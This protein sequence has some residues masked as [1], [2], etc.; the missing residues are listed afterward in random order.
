MSYSPGPSYNSWYFITERHANLSIN[1]LAPLATKL[2]VHHCIPETS[3]KTITTLG[4][5]EFKVQKSLEELYASYPIYQWIPAI[6]ALSFGSSLGVDFHKWEQDD[7]DAR[8]FLKTTYP[9][10]KI[11]VFLDDYH[12]QIQNTNSDLFN[13]DNIPSDDDN[14]DDL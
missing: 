9:W 3:P 8:A 6:L 12:E 1:P 5:I 7:F 4:F 10:N 13:P 11:Y 2:I 14:E